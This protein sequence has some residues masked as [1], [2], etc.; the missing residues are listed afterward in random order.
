MSER[1]KEYAVG[2]WNTL[3]NQRNCVFMNNI[4]K[5]TQFYV[6]NGDIQSF[7]LALVR[8]TPALINI[9]FTFPIELIV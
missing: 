8:F 9:K 6:W 1:E 2:S 7:H 3:D 5:C 4:I